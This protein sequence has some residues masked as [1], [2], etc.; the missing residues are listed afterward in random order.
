[1]LDP[2]EAMESF[3]P[4]EATA[5]IDKADWYDVLGR[6][7]RPHKG[8]T[9]LESASATVGWEQCA[10]AGGDEGARGALIPSWRAAPPAARSS[11]CRSSV[12]HETLCAVSQPGASVGPASAP[13]EDAPFVA[14]HS[15]PGVVSAAQL[16]PPA[17]A[18]H[19]GATEAGTEAEAVSA[20]SVGARRALF[21]DSLPDTPST[22]HDG[23]CALSPAS[24]RL[25]DLDS[26][27]FAA[28]L[29]AHRQR[30]EGPL[31]SLEDF[32]HRRRQRP[33]ATRPT[34]CRT[35]GAVVRRCASARTVH[36]AEYPTAP[37]A[38]WPPAGWR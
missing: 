10:A 15:T 21:D 26:A 18:V 32:L 25:A 31:E 8:R 2:A 28:R 34:T 23:C 11:R 4:A 6:F 33:S 36:D 16:P 13:H 12:D 37:R 9:V 30:L 3:R 27:V 22:R 5:L 19:A 20:A 1:M 17:A 24:Q 35:P 7:E 38:R 29:T 14:P